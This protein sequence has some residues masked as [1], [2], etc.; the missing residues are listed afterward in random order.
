MPNDPACGTGP[1]I[2]DLYDL[3]S[4][5]E[6]LIYSAYLLGGALDAL[7][8]KN[9]PPVLFLLNEARCALRNLSDELS[10]L[11]RRTKHGR[12]KLCQ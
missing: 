4:N 10:E 12:I 2:S 5:A 3:C 1:A 6:S 9:T 7:T 8:L 11:E